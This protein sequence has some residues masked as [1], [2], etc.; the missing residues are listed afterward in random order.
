MSFIRFR[1]GM[2]NYGCWREILCSENRLRQL[3]RELESHYR[4]YNLGCIGEK[5]YLRLVK[6]IDK[7]IGNLEMA[8][9]LDTPVS[10]ESFLQHS[11]KLKH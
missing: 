4:Q 5:E 9:L 1:L 3:Q 2:M 7:A 8:I 6:P 10:R 11:H